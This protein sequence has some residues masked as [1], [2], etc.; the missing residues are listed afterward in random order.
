[1]RQTGR[2][3]DGEENETKEWPSQNNSHNSMACQ[4]GEEEEICVVGTDRFT[5]SSFNYHWVWHSGRC[6]TRVD[7]VSEN[8]ADPF[9]STS[10]TLKHITSNY[11]KYNV[12]YRSKA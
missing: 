6:Y 4:T 12:N 3:S 9:H 5:L 11:V 2:E 8:T 1:M 7:T 10:L